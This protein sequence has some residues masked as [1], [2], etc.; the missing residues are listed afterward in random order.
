VSIIGVDS[1]IQIIHAQKI[2]Q[3][4]H[5]HMK[6]IDHA[7]KHITSTAQKSG[8]KPINSTINEISITKGRNQFL[9]VATLLRFDS[10]Q[11]AK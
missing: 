7:T 4:F 8:C 1:I 5:H 9:N 6:N 3:R 10:S 2:C 11:S